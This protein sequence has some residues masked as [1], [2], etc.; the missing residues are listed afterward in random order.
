[1]F[2]DYHMHSSFS[3]D[4]DTPMEDMVREAIRLGLDEICFTEHVDYD[5]PNVVPCDI[6][7]YL[8]RLADIRAQYGSRI[9]IRTGIEFG[10]QP[11]TV[12]LYRRDFS[13]HAFDFVILS[14]H[15][16]ESKEL[17]RGDYQRGKSQEDYQRAYY[18]VLYDEMLCYHDWSVLG[19]LDLIKR[20]DPAGDY[21]DEKIL[22]MAEKILRLAIAEGKGIELNTSCFRYGLK[23]LTPSRRLLELYRDLGGRI[24]TLGSDAHD[25]AHIAD[26]F[27]EARRVLREIGFREF[28]TFEQMRPVFH[29]LP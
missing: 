8:R 10:V 17:C 29:P 2:A 16:I 15:Q 6:D 9:R 1:M 18:Q 4:S 12:G 22:P 26:H 21:P 25:P 3:D 23:D 13:R 5:V 20:Y 7:A 19:H 14:C 27:P 28:C 24:L 11:H